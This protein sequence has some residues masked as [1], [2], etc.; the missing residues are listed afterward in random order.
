M[1]T[2]QQC[3][4]RNT[5]Q[6]AADL[7]PANIAPWMRLVC[8]HHQHFFEHE[9]LMRNSVGILRLFFKVAKSCSWL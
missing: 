6:I 9:A 1:L 7:L 4:W 8:R 3:A 2:K 5:F